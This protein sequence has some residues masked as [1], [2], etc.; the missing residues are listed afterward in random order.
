[1]RINANSVLVFLLIASTG[2][3]SVAQETI[4]PAN[5]DAEKFALEVAASPAAKRPALQG[6][7]AQALDYFDKSLA[8]F[9]TDGD[10]I[11]MARMLSLIGNARYV[12]GQYDHALEAYEKSRELT[13]NGRT[14]SIA[15]MCCSVSAPFTWPNKNMLRPCTGFTKH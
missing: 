9:Q 1:M 2:I 8:R 5:G 12:Q 14:I 13:S 15:R 4:G 3:I 6:N 11:G 7:N 10:H